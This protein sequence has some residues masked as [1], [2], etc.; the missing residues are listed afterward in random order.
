[1]SA[2]GTAT[3]LRTLVTAAGASFLLAGFLGRLPAAMNQLG[4]LLI[5]SASGRGLALAGA[6]VAAVGLGTALSAPV[7]GRLVDRYGPVPVLAGA[8]LLQVAGL[9]GVLVCLDRP[10]P[11][12]VVLACAGLVGLANPQAGSIT[13]ATWS[14]LS[15]REEDPSRSLGII[16]SGLGLESAADEVSFVVGPVSVGALVALLGAQGAM[17]GLMVSTAVGEGLL[18]AWLLSRPGLLGPARRTP[19]T[20]PGGGPADGR[21]PG[22]TVSPAS[23]D[24]AA[25]TGT[26]WRSLAP[27]LLAI[28]AVGVVFGTTQTALTAVHTAHG[29]PGL[30]GPVYGSMGLTSALAG[31]LTP[32]WPR[33]PATKMVTGGLL[34]AVGS[35][36]LMTVPATAATVAVILLMGAGVGTTLVTAYTLLEA[37]AAGGRVTSLMTLGATANILGVS[38]ASVVTGLLGHNLHAG[39]APAVAAGLVLVVV[40]ARALPLRRGSRPPAPPCATASA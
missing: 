26:P 33:S 37:Q 31:L 36:A 40:G 3:G 4:L 5:V 28:T 15:R 22:S 32:S 18:I 2:R 16:R 17:A 21:G 13:R 11:G 25:T 1:M 12:T 10:L 34:V 27:V 38:A 35:A 30:T 39:N 9:A 7:I 24:G 29:T 19:P 20:G 14:A 8:V 23:P 6:T